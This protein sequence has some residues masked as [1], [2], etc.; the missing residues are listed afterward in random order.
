M[1]KRI[2]RTHGEYDMFADGRYIGSRASYAQAERDLDAYVFEALTHGDTR[3]AT[4]LDG[5][6]T[7]GN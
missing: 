7:G 4:E 5:A 2:T 3:T 6:Q 1:T